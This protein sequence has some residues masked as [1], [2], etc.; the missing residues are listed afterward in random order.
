MRQL[1]WAEPNRSTPFVFLRFTDREVGIAEAVGGG[2]RENLAVAS[3]A[4]W[5]DD[6]R[7]R[8]RSL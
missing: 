8:E 4:L 3:D 2:D 1:M 5:A 7:C 6:G